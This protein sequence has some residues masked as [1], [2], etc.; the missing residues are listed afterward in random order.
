MKH[1]NSNFSQKSVYAEMG[2]TSSMRK[3]V[4]TLCPVCLQHLVDSKAFK[5]AIV[6][7]VDQ[8]KDTCSIC[9]V[10]RGFDYIV[11]SR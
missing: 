10:K 8:V 5:V 3:S 1:S 11:I 2:L 9:Q 7:S 6:P 4:Q